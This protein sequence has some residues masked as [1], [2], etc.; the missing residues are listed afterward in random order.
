MLKKSANNFAARWDGYAVFAPALQKSYAEFTLK[1]KR[2]VRAGKTPGGLSP[3]DLD[4][5]SAKSAL[6]HHPYALFSAGHY[7]SSVIKPTNAVSARNTSQTTII[8]DSGGYQIGTGALKEIKG[9]GKVRKPEKIMDLWRDASAREW[10]VRWLNA[11]CDY[12]MTIDI[13]LWAKT[14]PKADDSPFRHLSFEQDIELT[15][16][17]LKYIDDDRGRLGRKTK[18]LNVLHGLNSHQGTEAAW[19]ARVKEFDFEG[20]AFASDTGVQGGIVNLLRRLKRMQEDQQ[21]DNKEWLHFLGLSRIKSAVILT[22]IQRSLRQSCSPDIQISYDSA[23]ASLNAGKAEMADVP[24]D[25][26]SDESTWTFST[27][28]FPNSEA[29]A[30]STEIVPFPYQ[31]SPL[32]GYV[33]VNDMNYQAG[34]QHRNKFDTLSYQL[35]INHNLYVRVQRLVEANDL[36]FDPTMQ[37]H[38]LVPPRVLDAVDVVERVLVAEQWD[39][40]LSANADLLDSVGR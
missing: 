37:A 2:Q 10:I 22:A 24:K 17:S 16:E 28:R 18:W 4:F 5:L 33:S 6:W 9:W 35:L 38:H 32:A 31:S 25:F 1:P 15:Y 7:S 27:E 20:W 26:S 8:G 39:T 29:I 14:N 30:Q 19:Y 11:Y 12:S 34:I 3:R 40:L 36:V 23:S 13:P 21:L